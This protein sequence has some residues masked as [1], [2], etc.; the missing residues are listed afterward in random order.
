VQSDEQLE[1]RA[2]LGIDVGLQVL[3]HQLGFLVQNLSEVLN[4]RHQDL[5]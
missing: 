5:D 2:V 1:A 3:V 4:G